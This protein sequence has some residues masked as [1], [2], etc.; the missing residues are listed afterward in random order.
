MMTRSARSRPEAHS[1][2][3]GAPGVAD[4]REGPPRLL[5]EFLR[6]RRERLRPEDLG[7]PRGTRRRVPGLRR[8]EA[9]QLCGISST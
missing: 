2:A 1:G 4:E 6:A 8:E 9:A 5:G 7:L 3:A